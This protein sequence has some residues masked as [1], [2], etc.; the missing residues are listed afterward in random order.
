MTC[1]FLVVAHII[2]H[3]QVSL[4]H[5]SDPEFHADSVRRYKMYLHLKKKH[6][7]TFLVPCYDMDL[8]WHAHQVIFF[9][10]NSSKFS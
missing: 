1:H 8:V 6:P 9:S 7:K 2:P 3:P 5:F 10:K 4:P